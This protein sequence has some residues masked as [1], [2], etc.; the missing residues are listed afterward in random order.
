MLYDHHAAGLPV[1]AGHTPDA[2]CGRNVTAEYENYWP[3]L[4]V[5]ERICDLVVVSA[6]IVPGVK[7]ILREGD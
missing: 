5:A 6:D 7:W 1:C 4:A 2:H 3:K